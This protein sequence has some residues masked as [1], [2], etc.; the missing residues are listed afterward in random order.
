MSVMW[1]EGFVGNKWEVYPRP[2]CGS[3]PGE[4]NAANYLW[5]VSLG[6][7]AGSTRVVPF[8]HA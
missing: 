5:R 8:Q 7:G 3:M 4:V 6:P 2:R 1:P